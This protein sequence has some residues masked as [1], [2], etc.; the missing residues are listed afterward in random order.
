MR[1]ST[2]ALHNPFNTGVNWGTN[3]KADLKQGIDLRVR[4]QIGY[5]SFGNVIKRIWKITD[6][7]LK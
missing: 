4:S 3:C 1:P 5:Q 2:K 7:G 6:I